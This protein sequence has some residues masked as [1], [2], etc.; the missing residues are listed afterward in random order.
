[1]G[2][3]VE[4]EL[5]TATL[6]SDIAKYI[7]NFNKFLTVYLFFCYSGFNESRNPEIMIDLKVV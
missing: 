1:M 6:D 3:L 2:E 7:L 5:E 4:L